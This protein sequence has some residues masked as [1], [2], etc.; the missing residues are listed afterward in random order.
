[1]IRQKSS[2][3]MVASHLLATFNDICFG[4]FCSLLVHTLQVGYHIVLDRV[5][6]K[7][8][9]ASGC[10]LSSKRNFDFGLQ[11]CFTKSLDP[12]VELVHSILYCTQPPVTPDYR[13]CIHRDRKA[14]AGGGL[15]WDT[16]RTEVSSY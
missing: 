1:M 14:G 4:L 3:N 13:V 9:E 7:V 5:I 10:S 8:R 11:Y 16:R 12:T 2:P 6:K 15:A